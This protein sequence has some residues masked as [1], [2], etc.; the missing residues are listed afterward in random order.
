MHSLPAAIGHNGILIAQVGE[1]SQLKS[2]PEHI[3]LNRN[4]VNFI[5]TLS[6]L[7][8]V[9]LRDYEE[10]CCIQLS[11]HVFPTSM[12]LTVANETTSVC[13]QAHGGFERPWQ[14]LVASKSFD[15]MGRWLSDSTL[16]NYNIRKRTIP[17]KDGE[18][19]LLYFDGATM[20][21][22][23]YP[24][25]ASEVVFCRRY[26]DLQNCKTGHGFDQEKESLPI[27]VMEVRTFDDRR[28]VFA[29]RDIPQ[30]SYIGLEDAVHGVYVKTPASKLLDRMAKQQSPPVPNAVM[31]FIDVFGQEQLRSVSQPPGRIDHWYHPDSQ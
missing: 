31:N 16:V 26:G 27:S 9:A 30:S 1:A 22:Y 10:V 7:G 25:K 13:E 28:G 14:M 18:S 4:R 12:R 20:F 15:T 3:S 19:P 5:R 23:S 11:T 2:P 29:T 8:F 24:S 17:T 6:D 21:S